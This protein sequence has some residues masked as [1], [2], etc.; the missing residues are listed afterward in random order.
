[1]FLKKLTWF[2]YSLSLQ[3]KKILIFLLYFQNLF[4][5][6][7]LYSYMCEATILSSV[8]PFWLDQRH[9]QTCLHIYLQETL[10]QWILKV[11]FMGMIDIK[12]EEPNLIIKSGKIFIFLLNSN[13]Q[14]FIAKEGWTESNQGL[15]ISNSKQI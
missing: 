15:Y 1:M 10:P 7:L 2:F 14:L 5:C 4:F 9:D 8:R 13:N 3:K 11:F 12:I 6:W